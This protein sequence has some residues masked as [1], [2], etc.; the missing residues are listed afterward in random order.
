M[1]TL[2]KQLKHRQY[3]YIFVFLCHVNIIKE[4]DIH[5]ALTAH[6]L[7]FLHFIIIISEHVDMSMIKVNKRYCH[8]TH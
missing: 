4:H 8:L 7:A 6:Q 3:S 1:S 5:E 2:L